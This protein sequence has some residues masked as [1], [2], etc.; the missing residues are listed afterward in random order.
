M[1][2]HALLV[3]DEPLVVQANYVSNAIALHRAVRGS[4][5]QAW[6]YEATRDRAEMMVGGGEAPHA[7]A[8]QVVAKLIIDLYSR[9]VRKGRNPLFLRHNEGRAQ[10]MTGD[11][12]LIALATPA[13][14]AGL[15]Q[16]A[17]I[18]HPLVLDILSK[19]AEGEVYQMTHDDVI[20]SAMAFYDR[21][22]MC[23]RKKTKNQTGGEAPAV[24]GTDV[25]EAPVDVVDVSS[26]DDV[27][28]PVGDA[29]GSREPIRVPDD[30]QAFVMTRC[31]WYNAVNAGWSMMS[32]SVLSKR[33]L[34]PASIGRGTFQFLSMGQSDKAF[35]EL[36]ELG[37]V[38]SVEFDK[39]Y[40]RLQRTY[41]FPRQVAS[42]L[43]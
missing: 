25:G 17:N 20:L 31:K 41:P 42:L 26:E 13:G 3:R 23:L 5:G 18:L 7:H 35:A 22:C 2:R 1:D 6:L 4:E 11:V 36:R 33:A 28:N 9:A 24:V 38:D 30:L 10:F 34:P 29:G 37:I 19:N 21:L 39:V 14:S 15:A 40:A 16:V 12:T 43:D 32:W 27:E 8:L